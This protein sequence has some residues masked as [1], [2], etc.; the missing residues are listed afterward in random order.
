LRKVKVTDCVI[1]IETTATTPEA[2]IVAIGLALFNFDDLVQTTKHQIQLVK[3]SENKLREE[4]G[5]VMKWW[6]CDRVSETAR[7]QLYNYQNHQNGCT[8]IEGLRQVNEILPKSCKV[9]GNGSVFDITIIENAYKQVGLD[10]PWHFRAVCDIRTSLRTFKRY[11][12]KVPLMKDIKTEAHIAQNDAEHECNVLIA[13]YKGL[14]SMHRDALEY[15]HIIT[16]VEG[17]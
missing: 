7:Q 3:C 14:D 9:W 15:Q 5:K 1:D 2:G 16:N 4:D 17:I 10:V 13:G 11:N 6:S 12:V 8:L